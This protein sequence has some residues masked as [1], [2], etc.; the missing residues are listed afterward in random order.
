MTADP[1]CLCGRPLHYKNAYE[2]RQVE[3]IIDRFGEFINVKAG[4]KTYRVPR[5]YIALH[6]LK[7]KD[8]AALGFEEV[9]RAAV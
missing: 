5:H 8:L 6:G 9:G 2:R 3:R 7:D 4:A 1:R